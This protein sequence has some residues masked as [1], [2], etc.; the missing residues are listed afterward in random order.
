MSF[1]KIW[2]DVKDAAKEF[3][4]DIRPTLKNLADASTTFVKSVL[5]DAKPLAKVT[6]EVVK[7]AAAELH[8]Q[9]KKYTTDG[10]SDA[11]SS[12]EADNTKLE[13]E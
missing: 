12:V 5:D 11:S 9:I 7:D 1:K 4:H 6:A 2:Q 10:K 13:H 3:E 8:N